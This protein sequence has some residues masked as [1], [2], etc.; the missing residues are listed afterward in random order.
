RPETD[1][2]YGAAIAATDTRVLVGVPGDDSGNVNAGAVYA[3]QLGVTTE[4][5]VFRKRFVD[6]GFGTSIVADD[7][8]IAVGAPSDV[9]GK[10]AV[11]SFD[12]PPTPCLRNLCADLGAVAGGMDGSKFGQAAARVDGVTLIG[13]PGE[14]VDGAD[15]LGAAYLAV[16]GQAQRPRIANPET[17]AL[18]GDQFGF[19][20]AS[21]END[22]L[23]GAPLLGSTDTGAVFIFD[24]PSR[25]RPWPRRPAFP[26]SVVFSGPPAAAAGEPVAV[27]AP[28]DS[29][30]AWKAGA[31]YLFRRSTA[32][33]LDGKPLVSLEARERELFGAA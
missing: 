11:Y 2:Q 15:D 17:R 26:P 18:A 14:D 19:A 22:L 27:G 29:P 4:E 16:P 7:A 28:S 33:L 21:I 23:I 31:V 1:D 25:R 6:A 12:A 5:A 32:E 13:A 8:T 24:R 30:A 20:V 9:S 3:Y 10:G